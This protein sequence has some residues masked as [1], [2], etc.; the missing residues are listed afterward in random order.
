PAP[1]VLRV[2]RLS[3]R[4]AE[5]P[6]VLRE[7]DLEVGPGELVALVGPNGSGKTT[8]A[9]HVIGALRPTSGRVLVAGRDTRQASIGELARVVGYVAQNPDHQL[10]RATAREEVAFALRQLGL[11]RDAVARR[12]AETLARF[13]LEQLAET[14]LVLLSRGQRQLVAIAAALAGEPRLLV[15]DEPTSALDEAGRRLLG[16]LLVRRVADGASVLLISHDLRFVARYAQ[17]VVLLAEGEVQAEGS[18]RAILGDPELLATADLAPLPVTAVAWSLGLPPALEAHELVAAL[19]APSP[20]PVARRPLRACS[21]GSSPAAPPAPSRSAGT[22]PFLARLDPR[23]KLGLAV[24]AALPVLLWQSPLV[25]A[26]VTLLL[27]LL[28]RYGGGFSWRR[29]GELWRTLAPLLLLVLF[30]R[31]LFDRSGGPALFVVGPVVLTLPGAVAAVGAALRLV[32]LALL[33]LAW[34]ATSSERALV[35]ALV[36]LGLPT[37]VGLALAIGLRFIPVFAQTFSTAAEALQT[38]GWVIPERGMARLRA[39]LPVL[40]VA[41]AATLRQAQQL[42]WVLTVRGVGA[43]GTRPHFAELRLSRLDRF[44]LIGGAC[45]ELALLLATLAGLG[46][47][48]L[49]PWG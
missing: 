36:R 14:P 9:R 4:Y 19:A 20:R 16:E 31:P 6:E 24:G 39:L 40:S 1:P 45:A 10:V 18:P 5:G 38:R 28:L 7:V 43:R 41:L 32:V 46:R 12:T 23:V 22:A 35:Q 33:A 3:F 44:V 25:L 8:L 48:A 2:E 26:A 30:L 49:W 47:A 15:L 21:V 42:G 29:L 13:G 17:R 11:D 27:H 34:F 37:S